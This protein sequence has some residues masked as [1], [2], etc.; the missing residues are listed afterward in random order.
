MSIDVIIEKQ[1]EIRKQLF[2][3]AV[4]QIYNLKYSHK[5]FYLYILILPS[6]FIFIEFISNGP[7]S[8]EFW[9]IIAVYM[10]V[11]MALGPVS[12]YW[13]I[14]KSIKKIQSPNEIQHSDVDVKISARGLVIYQDGEEDYFSWHTIA[15]IVKTESLLLFF[16]ADG[17]DFFMPVSLLK[18]EEIEQIIKWH[19]GAK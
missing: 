13:K 10:L 6:I 15:K 3:K 9:L 4:Y 7:F 5:F 11:M 18:D 1:F 19:N 2:F 16:I 12:L 8:Y 17:L 14:H